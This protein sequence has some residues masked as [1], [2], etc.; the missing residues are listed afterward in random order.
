[1][2]SLRLVGV[3]I[4]V[5]LLMRVGCRWYCGTILVSWFEFGC[6]FMVAMLFSGLLGWLVCLV[7]LLICFLSGGFAL[8]IVF[9]LIDLVAGVVWLVVGIW[10]LFCCCWLVCFAIIFVRSSWFVLLL[11]LGSRCAFSWVLFGCFGISL[12]GVF[13]VLGLGCWCGLW[14]LLDLAAFVV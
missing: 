5:W 11:D 9:G 12:F 4:L 6:L 8:I 3:F 13:W 1:M 2:L 14:V 10:L 7:G